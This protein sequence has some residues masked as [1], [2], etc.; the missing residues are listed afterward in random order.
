MGSHFSSPAIVLGEKGTA[1]K[2]DGGHLKIR[3]AL[4]V[5]NTPEM[6]YLQLLF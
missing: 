4:P 3:D 6:S 1:A 5:Q 2:T